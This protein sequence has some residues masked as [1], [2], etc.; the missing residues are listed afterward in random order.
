MLEKDAKESS[1]SGAA[2]VQETK[3]AALDIQR[4][5]QRLLDSYLEQDIERDIYLKKKAELMSE[6]KS[7]EEKSI[8]FERDQ[9]GWVEP[10]KK[11]IKDAENLTKTAQDNDLHAKKV[12]AKEIF[13]SNL[14][15]SN[16]TIT[17]G[18]EKNG[19]PHEK[20]QWT[21]ILAAHRNLE[22]IPVSCLLVHSL[23]VEPKFSASQANVLSIER[24]VHSFT[25]SLYIPQQSFCQCN[26]FF[27][28][29]LFSFQLSAPAQWFHTPV[30]NLVLAYPFYELFLCN[31]FHALP[32]FVLD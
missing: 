7:L 8:K 11:W 22:K 19:E 30:S 27:L 9:N 31:R 32:F 4:K 12:V 2:L 15:L 10:M 6:K 25:A 29:F 26:L 21:A 1:R 5:L 16:K 18:E 13:G 20:N 3:D 28:I 23:G 24:R 17:W 14:S